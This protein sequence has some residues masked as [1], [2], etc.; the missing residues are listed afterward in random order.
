[1]SSYGSRHASLINHSYEGAGDD[2]EDSVEEILGLLSNNNR[3]LDTVGIV[4][5]SDEFDDVRSVSERRRQEGSSRNSSKSI[6]SA[7]MGD[8][9]ESTLN[10]VSPL[11]TSG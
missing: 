4:P 5:N 6:S 2:G 3:V 8:E 7:I 10:Q 11:P 9:E 1:M